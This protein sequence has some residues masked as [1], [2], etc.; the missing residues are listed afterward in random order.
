LSAGCPSDSLRQVEHDGQTGPFELIAEGATELS[1]EASRH[2]LEGKGHDVGVEPLGV[3]GD[4][5]VGRGSP[6][7]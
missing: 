7:R 6:V 1:R 3:K 4:R 5:A 2:V